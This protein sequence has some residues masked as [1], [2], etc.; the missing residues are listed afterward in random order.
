VVGVTR[1]IPCH[2][3]DPED[4]FI[5]RDGRQYDDDEIVTQDEAYAYLEAEHPDWRNTSVEKV[6]EVTEAFVAKTTGERIRNAL[7]RRRQ[8]RDACYTCP[9]RNGCLKLALDTRPS[10][11]TWGGYHEEELRKLYR[12]LDARQTE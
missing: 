6:R 11:G 3:G 2:E 10:S 12:A 7:V 8:A 9:I 1:E 5:R 4:W